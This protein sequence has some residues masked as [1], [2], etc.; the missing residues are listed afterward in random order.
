MPEKP[1]APKKT[2]AFIGFIAAG[3]LISTLYIY[4][5]YFLNSRVLNKREIEQAFE[6]PLMAEIYQ[7]D[8]GP[9]ELSLKNRSVLMEQIFNLRTNLRFLL[10]EHTDATTILITSSMSGE[11]KTFLSAHLGNSLTVNNKKVV[12]LELDLRKPKLS[13]FLG[14]DNRTGITNYIVENKSVDEIIKKIPDAE[15]LY[16][17]SSGPIPPNPVELIEGNR[18]R[19]LFAELKKRFDYIIIDTAPIGIVSDAK[20]LAPYVDCTLFMV[21]YN[22]TMKSK[23]KAVAENLKEGYFRKTGVIF[24]GIEQDS[25]HPYYYYDHYSYTENK[26]KSKRVLTIVKKLKHRI[27]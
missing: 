24:N 27:V 15:G 3:L 7:D 22:F 6:L 23:L 13:R 9:K 5:K 21:R 25:F 20:S 10:S 11:G 8:E 14:Q 16:L 26:V 2:V 19:T 12:L 1:E 17:I 4:I 18:M